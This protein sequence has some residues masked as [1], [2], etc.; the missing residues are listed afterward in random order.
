MTHVILKRQAL[1]LRKL[2]KSYSQIKKEL[3]VSKSTLSEWLREYPLSKEQIRLLRDINEE[4]IE[5]YRNTMRLKREAKQLTYYNEQKRNLIPLSQKEIYLAGLFLYW[6]EGAKTLHHQVDI[7]NTDPSVLKFV[8]HWMTT[9]LYIPKEKVRVNLHLYKDMNIEEIVD[10]WSEELHIPKN[11]FNRPYIKSTNRSELDQKGFGHGT[12]HLVVN[13]TVIKEK[14]LMGI[15]AM[16]DYAS[17]H[18]QNL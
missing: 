9:A 16:G 1:E 12:C 8:L 6:G 15:K 11:Q 14:I 13:N 3:N 10:F 7:S 2:G 18:I 5:K 4:R 17:E